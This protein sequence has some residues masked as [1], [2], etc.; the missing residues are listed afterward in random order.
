MTRM[1]VTTGEAN[2]SKSV[3]AVPTD[4]HRGRFLR[5]ISLNGTSQ[6]L[7]NALRSVWSIILCK[8]SRK[9]NK[10]DANHDSHEGKPP[11]R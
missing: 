5:R 2:E 1:P 11:I 9:S 10:G 6:Q 7:R 3:M 4:E 8:R